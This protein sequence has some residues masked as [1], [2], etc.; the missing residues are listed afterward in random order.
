MSIE[1]KLRNS[2]LKDSYCLQNKS[3]MPQHSLQHSSLPF[4]HSPWLTMPRPQ[5]SSLLLEH[6][7]LVSATEPLH[8][9]FP[10]LE[11]LLPRFSGCWHPPCPGLSSNVT[12]FVRSSPIHLSLFT[13][14]CPHP[15]PK[16]SLLC[17]LH[18]SKYQSRNGLFF[19]LCLY[20]L[21]DVISVRAGTCQSWSQAFC[22]PMVSAQ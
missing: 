20:L 11:S 18:P 15:Y 6:T 19:C 13:Q 17:L 9:L 7:K 4:P 16:N 5:A 14:P 2:V 3:Q 12:S 21:L 1:Q 22:L 10:Q 8:L